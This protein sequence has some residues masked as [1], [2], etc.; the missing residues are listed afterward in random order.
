MLIDISSPHLLT[1]EQIASF[2][3]N[4]FIRLKA[5]SNDM[6]RND[7]AQWCPGAI[8]GEIICTARNPLIYSC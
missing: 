2:R 1:A 6:Q 3:D 7:W 8:P 5:S 4:G